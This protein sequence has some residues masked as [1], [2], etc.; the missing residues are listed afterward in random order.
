MTQ[1]H[2]NYIQHTPCKLLNPTL[3]LALCINHLGE[4]APIDASERRTICVQLHSFASKTKGF[5]F[6]GG[7]TRLTH[8]EMVKSLQL[9]KKEKKED[10]ICF[11]ICF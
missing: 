1:W 4:G 10:V 2:K 6:W 8:S 9:K 5:W 7:D 11:D 3:E